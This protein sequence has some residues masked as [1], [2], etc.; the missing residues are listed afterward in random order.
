MNQILMCYPEYFDVTYDINPW[1]TEQIGRVNRSNAI[2]QWEKLYECLDR[3]ASIS[4]INPINDL[5]DLVFTANAGFVNKKN[6]VL[7]RF[8]KPERSKEEHYFREWFA[9]F[10]ATVSQPKLAYE[11]EGDHLCDYKHRHWLGSGFRTDAAVKDELEYFLNTDINVLELIDGRW[12]H[13]DTAFCPLPN[14]QILWYPGAFSS[15]SRE[16]IR[17]SFKYSVEVNEE[18]AMNFCCNAVVLDDNVFLPKNISVSKQLNAL[19]YRCHEFDLSEF[20]K[21]GGAAKCL[22]LTLS[23]N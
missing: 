9:K 10:A 14:G 7:S 8:S 5:P 4:L 22:V 16:I 19:S 12:Y 17:K 23:R 3:Y 20:L 11:G 15:I 6:I 18:D 21:S 13:L 2:N 1:M